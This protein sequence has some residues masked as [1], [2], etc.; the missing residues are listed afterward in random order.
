MSAMTQGSRPQPLTSFLTF[1]TT[2]QKKYKCSSVCLS[3]YSH[4]SLSFTRYWILSPSTVP[5]TKS[6]SSSPHCPTFVLEEPF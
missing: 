5:Y 6:D 2:N 1:Q 3:F 4:L